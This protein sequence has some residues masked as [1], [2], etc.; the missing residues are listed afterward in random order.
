MRCKIQHIEGH[1]IYI[2][3]ILGYL[4]LYAISMSF[5]CILTCLLAVSE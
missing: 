5:S 3:S 1:L 4:A 2:F